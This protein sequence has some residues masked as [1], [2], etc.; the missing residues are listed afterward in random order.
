[1]IVI[2]SALEK[3][4]AEGKPIRVGMVGA[5]FMGR[6]IAYQ[7]VN[8][9]QGMDLV[10]ICN[11]NLAGAVRAF[12][13]AGVM[14]V[15]EAS[16]AAELEE[17]IRKGKFSVTEDPMALCRA[18]NVDVIL[19]VTGDVAYGA[20]VILEAIQQGK[21]A[22][23]FSAE[24]DSTLGPILEVRADAAGVVYSNC[25][26]DQP[27][28][29]MNLH[30]FVVGIGMKPVLCGNIKGLQDPYRNPT[31]QEAFAKKWNQKANMVTSFADGS[32]I[33][34]EQAI[35][36]NA[37]GMRVGKLGM[38][39]PTVERGVHVMDA[40]DQYPMEAMMSGTGI[41]DY[42][43]GASPAPGVFIYA[44]NDNKAMQ[45]YLNLYK[46]GEGP[47]Y[48]FYRPYH[49]CHFEVPNSVARAAIFGDATIAP[50]GAPCVEVVAT[51][52]IDLK[53]G[54]TL[55]GI[56]YFMTY[57]QCENADVVY[58]DGLLPMGLAEGCTLKRDIMMDDVLTYSDVSLPNGR[59]IDAL[60][61]EQS[62]YF[63]L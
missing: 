56:G 57:G 55:D 29:T 44:T 1:M 52:K 28:V 51:A 21:H 32:K 12:E 5:G 63:G 34:F 6:G 37:T 58:R 49:L 43:V 62:E 59:L 14:E 13:E 36:A 23:T 42:I 20:E 26:G 54:E 47:L 17:N 19:E 16:S 8:V 18:G 9:F 31:T 25:D 10:A 48:C 45:H 24:L 38:F 22:L 60:W 15:V 40:V 30:R 46:L 61:E 50:L 35:V 11:R 3:L 4:Q 7:M 27:G 39:G 53:A 33:S 41:V 2:D